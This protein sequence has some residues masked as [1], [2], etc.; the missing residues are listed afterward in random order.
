MVRGSQAREE[1]Q[2]R[3]FCE[4]LKATRVISV[5]EGGK[6]CFA[7][8]KF[9]HEVICTPSVLGGKRSDK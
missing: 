5:G 6:L 4:T 9:Q 1:G 3:I 7:G 8:A 2:R